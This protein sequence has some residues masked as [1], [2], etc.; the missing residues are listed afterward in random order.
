MNSKRMGKWVIVLFLLA[1]LPGM[2]A[3]MAQGQEPAAKQPLPPVGIVMPASVADWGETP[4]T[5]TIFEVESNNTKATAMWIDIIDGEVVGGEL[6]NGD[7]DW[8][9]FNVPATLTGVLMDTDARMDGSQADT[10]LKLFDNSGSTAPISQND[11]MGGYPYYDS[12]LY[13]VLQQGWYYV[14]VS[15]YPANGNCTSSCSYDLIIS[16]PTLISAA[17]A[18][19]GTGNV[20]G[21]PFRSED[22]LSLQPFYWDAAGRA[23]HKWRLFMD[24]S[25]IGI[26]KPVVNIGTGWQHN[27]GTMTLTFGANQIWEDWSGVNRTFKPWDWAMVAFERVGTNTRLWINENGNPAVEHHPGAEHG[28]TTLAEKVDALDV[29]QVYAANPAW[30]ADI[31]L[32]TTG[33]ASVPTGA[34][35]PGIVKAADEDLIK[36]QTW[37]GNWLW[38][39]SRH[40]DGSTVPGLAAEDIFA[41]DYELSRNRMFLVI[42]GTGNI[43][44]HAVTQK[45]IFWL[46]KSGSAWTWGGM[47]HLPDYGWNYNLDAIETGGN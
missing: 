31:F 34:G 33:A 1:A 21:I 37:D 26:N 41:A 3:V 30:T 32:S 47:I 43:M 19:L 6:Y 36:S 15:D 29:N 4:V 46:D 16:R 24:G 20:E 17:A 39:N 11:D 35:A 9:K 5:P 14:E 38:H 8:Y 12:V 2:T 7:V 22:V 25:D 27:Y 18:N 44:G 23:N 42:L 40:F 13:A 10:V 28:L 45:D